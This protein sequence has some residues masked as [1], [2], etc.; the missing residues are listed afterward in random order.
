LLSIF[1]K[2]VPLHDPLAT[3]I[4]GSSIDQLS[5]GAILAHAQDS[6]GIL[7]VSPGEVIDGVPTD[8]VTLVPASAGA[9]AGLTREIVELSTATH[10]PV[11]VI[12]YADTQLVRKVDFS[13]VKVEPVPAGQ[14][15]G[16]SRTLVTDNRPH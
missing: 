15:S 1:K 9:D 10:L 4:R 14:V 13:N 5:F 16:A 7:S 2:T 12:G 8:A 6:A 3:T 11:R